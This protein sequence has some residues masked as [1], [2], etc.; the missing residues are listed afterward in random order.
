MTV[1]QTN[2]RELIYKQ[3]IN[4]TEICEN[5]FV[6]TAVIKSACMAFLNIAYGT[7]SQNI[8]RGA[9][10]PEIN[11]VTWIKSGNNMAPLALVANLTTRWRCM[12]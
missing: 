3:T 4:K 10:Y 5:I 12:H 9:M 11:S 6:T 8:A 1:Q 7:S 2:L